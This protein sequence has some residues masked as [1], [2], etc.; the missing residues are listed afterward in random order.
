MA[1]ATA[2]VRVGAAGHLLLAGR[3]VTQH[4]AISARHLALTLRPMLRAYRLVHH[5]VGSVLD[6][7]LGGRGRG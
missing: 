6:R 2:R 7:L 3:H 4:Q 1:M 5:E